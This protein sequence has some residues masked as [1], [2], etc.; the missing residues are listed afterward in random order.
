MLSRLFGGHHR[1]GPPPIPDDPLNLEPGWFNTLFAHLGWDAV[2]SRVQ[3]QS[4]GTGQI[5]LN[6]RFTIAYKR[7][8]SNAPASIVGKFPS[9]SET[10][11]A[12]AQALGHYKREVFFYRTF[13]DVARRIAPEALY[14]DYDGETNRFVL[15]MEDMAPS[16]Q[17]DQ[18]RGCSLAEAK[19]AMDYA[20]ILHAAHWNDPDLDGYEWL[21]ASSSAPQGP[22][23]LEVIEGLW[24]GFKERYADRLTGDEERVGDAYAGALAR[25]SEGYDGPRCLTHADY[26]LDNMLFGDAYAQK[27]LV[28]VDWQTAGVRGPAIDVAYFIGAGLTRDIRPQLERQLLDHYH[29]AL[30]RE[31]VRYYSQEQLF[32]HYRW[33]SFFG[34]SVAFAAAMLVEQTERGDEMFLTM[35]RRH[36]DHILALDAL[37]LLKG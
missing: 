22:I 10:S 29:A 17:G 28:V 24:H 37:D 21:E 35:T 27:P 12:A 19:R 3:G 5:G 30:N 25:W 1:S 31:G 13:P 2:V 23:T 32:Q 26:R 9:Y 7:N 36:V 6:V 14:T 18:L 8:R 34:L 20:A 33:F 15:L 16:V 4:V 11:Q